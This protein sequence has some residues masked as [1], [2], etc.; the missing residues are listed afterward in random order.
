MADTTWRMFVPSIIGIA[1]GYFLDEKLGSWPWI[2]ITGTALGCTIAGI[3]IKRQL[4]NT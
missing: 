4:Q 3:L 2:F 1:G